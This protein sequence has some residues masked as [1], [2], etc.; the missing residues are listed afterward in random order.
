MK[1]LSKVWAMPSPQSVPLVSQKES[2][3][4]YFVTVPESVVLPARA[5]V[6]GERQRNRQEAARVPARM[7]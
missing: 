4:R 6:S 5:G 1:W 7:N 2:G 3:T